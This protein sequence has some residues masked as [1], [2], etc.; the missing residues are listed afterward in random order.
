MQ[1]ISHIRRL[2]AKAFAAMLLLTTEALLAFLL[3]AAAIVVFILISGYV[4]VGRREDF[5]LAVFRFLDGFVS[6][7]NNTVMLFITQLGNHQ[8][9]IAANLT[10]IVYFLFI[11][12]HKWYSIK[13]PA[14]A[15]GSVAIMLFLKQWFNRARPEIP[16]LEPALGLSFPSGHAMSSVTFYGLLIYFIWKQSKMSFAWRRLL[17]ALLVLLILLI[18]L[19]RVYLR[20]HY[21]SDVVGGFCTGIIWLFVAIKLMNR[22]QRFSKKRLDPMVREATQV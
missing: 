19:S 4:F 21:A 7:A 14:V 12:R 5:D 17:V 9:L 6:E 16:L 10:L 11:R 20:V 13:V 15:L 18:G 3:F 1:V 22:M 2:I 8:F